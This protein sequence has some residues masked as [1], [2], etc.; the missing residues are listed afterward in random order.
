MF[1]VRPHDPEPVYAQLYRQVVRAV[2]EGRLHP[3]AYLP[4]VRQVAREHGINPA[5]VKKAYDA[6]KSDG[7][8]HTE[9]RSGTVVVVP[10]RPEPRVVAEVQEKLY[11]VCAWAIARGVPRSRVFSLVDVILREFPPTPP[12]SPGRALRGASLGRGLM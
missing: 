11:D 9:N 6:L 12:P 8:V 3:G 2:A 10:E 4:S 1:V 5:T 7:V